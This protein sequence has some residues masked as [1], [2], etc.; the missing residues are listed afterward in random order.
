MTE[1]VAAT[2]PHESDL[3]ATRL[4]ALSDG[5]YAIAM[6]LLVINVAIPAHLGD[7]AFHKALGDA[8]PNVGAFA[9]SFSLI[10]GF[11]RDHRRILTALPTETVVITRLVLLGLGL[12]ALLPFPTALL[13]EY[14]SQPE[15]VALY[16]G[17]LA[18]IHAVHATLLL[19]T[20][21]QVH[22]SAASSAA[23]ARRGFTAQLGSSVLI[24]GLSVPL[25]FVN[26]AAAMWFWITLLP[27]HYILGQYHRRRPE[28]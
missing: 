27:A 19:L 4:I 23:A 28:R 10:A 15:T 21:R 5:I 8:L 16:A 20:Q 2:H 26:T 14:A 9:L 11:W 18:A 22:P 17:T 1:P 25:A 7:A 3:G 12:V 6:T 13:A 24:F